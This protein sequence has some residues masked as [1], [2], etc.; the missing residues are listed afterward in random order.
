MGTA[1]QPGRVSLTPVFWVPPAASLPAAY[2]AGFT[3]FD[4][5]VAS[6]AGTP[7]NVF[8]VETQYTDAKGRALLSAF[9]AA[10]TIVDT[11]PYP[12]PSL[13]TSCQA[14]GGAVYADGTGYVS[15]LTDAQIAAELAREA[16][17]AGIPQDRAH[18]LTMI[19]PKGVEVCFSTKNT[20][21]GGSCTLSKASTRSSGSFCAYHSSGD[22]QAAGLGLIYAVIPYGSPDPPL[23]LTCEGPAEHPSGNAPLDVALSAYSH[24]VAE[25]VTDP[26]GAGW[27]DAYGNENGDLCNDAFG[28]VVS[29]GGSGYNQLIGGHHY[30]LQQEF[31][32]I[33]WRA[34]PSTG[35][36]SSWV[37]PSVVLG[38]TGPAIVGKHLTVTATAT[39][40][41]AK[42]A[43]YAWTL[44]GAP[45][46]GTSRVVLSF[47]SAGT[48]LVAV[49]VRDAAGWTGTSSLSVTVSPR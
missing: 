25:A 11:S 3:D 29:P 42:V 39:A 10:S 45:V 23:K 28:M 47:P 5:A 46:A 32:N 8:A 30:L 34:D 33:A 19:L 6:D 17:A 13:A 44:D 20:A 7:S 14:D 49:T 27:H 9:S 22:G 37:P 18:L 1:S 31:S 15:C 48:H 41:S 21:H 26:T 35:C 24:E 4:A 40:G 12:A 38:A 16:T 2:V 43:G 36:Q